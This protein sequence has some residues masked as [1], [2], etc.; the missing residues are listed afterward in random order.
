MP[1]AFILTSNSSYSTSAGNL[2]YL[3]LEERPGDLNPLDQEVPPTDISEGPH[4][5][6]YIRSKWCAIAGPPQPLWVITD[7]RLPLAPPQPHLPFLH[8][9]PSYSRRV[10]SELYIYRVALHCTADATTANYILTLDWDCSQNGWDI[11]RERHCVEMLCVGLSMRPTSRPTLWWL[12][13]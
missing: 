10:I 3:L 9:T 5:P 7:R 13:K 6:T 4:G 1:P 8:P 12:W 11:V 2:L